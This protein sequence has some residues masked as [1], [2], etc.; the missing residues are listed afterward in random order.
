MIQIPMISFRTTSSIVTDFQAQQ[1]TLQGEPIVSSVILH[2]VSCRDIIMA[3]LDLGCAQFTSTQIKNIHDDV[4]IAHFVVT[5][6]TQRLRHFCDLI[7]R[8]SQFVR[9]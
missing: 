1:K 5:E 7:Y 9:T 6:P 4:S 8:E 2:T 3:S